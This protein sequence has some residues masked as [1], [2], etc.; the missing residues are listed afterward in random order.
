[1]TELNMLEAINETLHAEMA[2][3][4]RVV[5]LGQD[6]ADTGGFYRDT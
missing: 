6:M 3:D 1:M 2:R 4:D 5:V